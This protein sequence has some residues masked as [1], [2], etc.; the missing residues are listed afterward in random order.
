MTWQN[1][2]WV[3][4][5][6]AWT[7]SYL[8]RYWRL[9]RLRRRH[10]D[11]VAE[12]LVFIGRDVEIFA[13]SGYGRVVLGKWVHLGDG[14]KLRA[15]EG[16]LRVGDKAVFG[17]SV[18]V[19]CLLDIEIGAACLVGDWVYV[20]DFD[21]VTTDPRVPIKDQGVVKSPVRIGPDCWLGTKASV[22]KGSMIGR[23]S[24][25]AA[26]TVVRGEV[27][28]YSVVAGVPGRVRHRRRGRE[29]RTSA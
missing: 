2:I 24:V 5:H 13:R 11:V 12:G 9:A 7:P 23:G 21:H 25:L 10:P 22:L 6:R 1:L 20:C 29:D 19:N 17:G 16:T 8:V 4:R 15:H 27:P 18:V 28:D 26:H 3:A 14:T